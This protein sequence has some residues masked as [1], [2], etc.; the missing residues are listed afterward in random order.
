MERGRRSVVVEDAGQH[1][2]RLTRRDFLLA[3]AGAGAGLALVGWGPDEA[4]N[5]ERYPKKFFSPLYE[6]ADPYVIREGKSYYTTFSDGFNRLYVAKSP[7][8]LHRRRV[9]LVHTFPPG[10]WNS[11]ELW[12]P[13]ALIRWD[14]GRWYL[15]Y[16]A[17]DGNNVNHR[18]GV[19]RADTGNP[20]G[21]YTDLGQVNTGDRWAIGATAFQGFE[22]EWYLTWS[23]WEENGPFPQVTYVAPMENPWTIGDRI[24][25]SRPDTAWEGVPDHPIQEG[26]MVFRRGDKLF[27]LYSANASWT[28]L[29]GLGMLT[30]TRRP[31]DGPE[32]ILDPERW[33]KSEGPVFERTEYV[34]GPGGPAV[35]RSADGA[36]DWLFYHS[37]QYPGS[38]WKRYMNAKKI[39]WSPDGTPEFGD[40]VPYYR[41]QDVPSGDPGRPSPNLYEAEDATLRGAAIVGRFAASNGKAVALSASLDSYAE[42][43]VKVPRAG[44]YNLWIRHATGFDGSSNAVSVNGGSPRSISYG[45]AGARNF[46]MGFMQVRL[47]AG[48]NTIR[49]RGEAATA[50]MD[51]VELTPYGPRRYEAEEATYNNAREWRGLPQASQGR[52]VGW[53]DFEDS[54]V[55]FDV[56]AARG[57]EHRVFAYYCTGLASTHNVSVNGGVRVPIRYTPLGWGNFYFE[58][59][60]VKLR[61]GANTITFA[62]G[63]GYAAL[64]FI[65]IQP[66]RG[67]DELELDRLMNTAP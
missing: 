60:D 54:Y 37:A 66:L 19:L 45:N 20:Q 9:E 6:G 49:V 39:E 64:D 50:E 38:G 44:Y 13:F 63:E 28:D 55:R 40:P 26:Q 65:E 52:A 17:S 42:F 58:M 30:Y 36:E 1:A 14:D 10:G 62:K 61:K 25:I 23:G 11:S 12:G 5:R 24:L 32:D 48:A 16:C 27:L 67:S 8:L 7:S 35:T 56:D 47:N 53:I 3:S 57:G 21:F 4:W 34:R 29:Y 59:I 2:R 41:S 33:V 51:L 18:Q 43:G 15:F 22:G 31:G 46:L